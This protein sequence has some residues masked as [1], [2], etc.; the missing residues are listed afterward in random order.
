MRR[1]WARVGLGLVGVFGSYLGLSVFMFVMS[2]HRAS[3][4]HNS[5]HWQWFPPL[6][7]HQRLLIVAPH[8]DD[9]VLGCGG[10]IAEAVQQGIPVRVVYL[11]AGDAFTGAATLLSRSTPD[12]QDYLALG[13]Q[14]IAEA[15]AGAKA[16]GLSPDDLV[17]LGFP[18]RALWRIACAEDRAV[19]STTTQVDQVPYPH[20][21]TYS[22]RY[23]ATNLA[24]NL[25]DVMLEFQPTDVFTTHPLDDH[26]DHMAGAL[27]TLEALRQAES[28]GRLPHR[29]RLYYY[30]VHRGDWPLP[31]GNYPHLWLKPPA[32]MDTFSWLALPLS[33]SAIERKEKALHAHATQYAMMTRFLSSF[34]RRNELF[35]PARPFEMHEKERQTYA[36]FQRYRA[37]G[38]VLVLNPVD[39]NP[40]VHLRPE[41]DIFLVSV[42]PKGYGL[43]VVVDTYQPCKAPHELR[44]TLITIDKQNRWHTQ[45][46]RYRGA[47]SRW[48]IERDGTRLRFW[49]PQSN[50]RQLQS[51]YLLVQTRL[52][53]VEIDRSGIVAIP[54]SDE[55]R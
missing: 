48:L 12:S 34:I 2:M 28:S 8:P 27:F 43:E 5:F 19:R 49:F 1:W 11:T 55:P 53:G 35:Q 13:T 22:Q 33:S 3:L 45:Q 52:Y 31:Q 50:L 46:W 16:L 17:F 24:Q 54:L 51:A 42:K 41:A 6:E 25:A 26:L 36:S 29:P 23:T 21:K 38:E 47:R 40:T 7:S 39:D 44:F 20:A 18:D 4:S 9:E 10:L 37:S 14:R 32:G 30:L 15:N